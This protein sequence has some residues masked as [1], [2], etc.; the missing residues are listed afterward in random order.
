MPA[1]GRST[2]PLP[3][4]TQPKSFVRCVLPGSGRSTRRA[5]RC[6]AD[7]S[8]RKRRP[9]SAPGMRERLRLRRSRFPTPDAPRSTAGSAPRELERALPIVPIFERAD[10]KTCAIDLEVVRGDDF[11][12]C[13]RDAAGRCAVVVLDAVSN[14]DLARIVRAGQRLTAPV[15]WVGTGGLARALAA[16]MRRGADRT[17]R[18]RSRG[19]ARS[20]DDRLR[21]R[22]PRGAG[23]DRARR[24]G[25][26]DGG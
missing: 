7:T 6:C 22:Q 24:C 2:W 17:Q 19:A 13:M 21:K 14:G 26:G 15:V 3:P 16:S 4:R 1:H 5:T 8:P 23:A 10:V 12:A 25:W 20:G 18:D 9:Y 11:D